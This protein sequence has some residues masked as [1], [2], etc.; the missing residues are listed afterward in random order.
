VTACKDGSARIF[1]AD[2]GA[3]LHRLAHSGVVSAIET[4]NSATPERKTQFRH[5]VSLRL[6][7]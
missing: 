1:V 3:L 2:S 5:G 6:E 4:C 7:G